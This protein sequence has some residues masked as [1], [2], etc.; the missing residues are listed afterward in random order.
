M[1]PERTTRER[2][3]NK[4]GQPTRP[5]NAYILWRSHF[6]TTDYQEVK[7]TRPGAKFSDILKEA[8][9]SLTK[10]E[11]AR[12]KKEADEDAADLKE[13]CPDYVYQPQRRKKVAKSKQA[14]PTQEAFN[15]PTI[16]QGFSA[17]GPSEGALLS[18]PR[19]ST[20]SIFWNVKEPT[21]PTLAPRSLFSAFN[22]DTSMNSFQ[23]AGPSLQTPLL[24]PEPSSA[25]TTSTFNP[26]DAPRLHVPS[27]SARQSYSPTLYD[28]SSPSDDGLCYDSSSEG[29]S[30][31]LQPASP[32]D[33]E[34]CLSDD[35]MWTRGYVAD[36][37]PL[38]LQGT[39]GHDPDYD[40]EKD[41]LMQQFVQ[42][43]H[44]S[45]SEYSSSPF[46]HG[47][48]ELG[49]DN[50]TDEWAQPREAADDW[51]QAFPSDATR[52]EGSDGGSGRG[53]HS[54][55]PQMSFQYDISASP[56]YQAGPQ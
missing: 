8:Y 28:Y 19:T 18:H 14:A 55:S 24:Y 25:G 51:L 41:P 2:K 9:A 37:T 20:E 27:S 35:L 54:S 3:R 23:K 7:K 31:Y 4:H 16:Q 15:Q 32:S 30:Y 13:Q 36:P 40:P 56:F 50:D 53:S 44:A 49:Y 1:S 22:M 21:P 38:D 6:V 10:E 17:P 52:Y 12:W 29:S 48:E 26:W 46:S 11:R 47:G 42:G 45:R 34:G 43:I 5:C 39:L 33:F